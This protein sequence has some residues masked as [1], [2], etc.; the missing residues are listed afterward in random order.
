M[1]SQEGV[2]MKK[3][4][5]GIIGLG[6]IACSYDHPEDLMIKT[7]IKACLADPRL[8][9]TCISDIDPMRANITKKVWNLNAD[10]LA[11]E[12]FFNRDLDIICISSPNET[13]LPMLVQASANPPRLVLCEKPLGGDPKAAQAAVLQ[14]EALGSKVAVNFI[15]RWIPGLTE[16]INLAQTGKL[17]NP[18]AVNVT[19][20]GG[21]WNNGSHAVDLISAFL[22]ESVSETRRW[23]LPIK[24]RSAQDPTISFFAACGN[25]PLWIRGVDGRIQ[26]VFSVE[27]LF[28][29]GC[30]RIKDEDGI[31]A[32]L[33]L[34]ATLDA[35]GYAPELRV[36]DQFFDK[37][38]TLM[39]RVWL[40]L[41]DHLLIGK[42]IACSATAALAGLRMQ[43]RL[44]QCIE[45]VAP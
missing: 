18:I 37:P 15:R 44:S 26:T 24:D 23:G 6:R 31:K 36:A 16:W 43:V 13:H 9:L 39:G 40:N 17:G 29:R 38:A 41:A 2:G 20:S 7:H 30:I 45:G 33:D 25:T 3:L 8:D 34:P 14:L 1:S 22:G 28:E 19:Y 35:S 4:R 11:Q 27:L 5:V 42:P 12:D 32:Q 10:I 21:F